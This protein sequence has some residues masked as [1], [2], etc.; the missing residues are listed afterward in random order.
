M[1]PVVYAYVVLSIPWFTHVNL[2][3]VGYTCF[4]MQFKMC[5]FRCEAHMA[6]SQ[7]IWATN[8]PWWSL[9]ILLSMLHP[10][11]PLVKQ[12]YL[13]SPRKCDFSDMAPALQK[14][15]GLSPVGFWEDQ[16][17][18]DLPSGFDAR[19]LIMGILVCVHPHSMWSEIFLGG[20][21]EAWLTSL[22]FFWGVLWLVVFILFT[23]QGFTGYMNNCKNLIHK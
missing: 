11:V 21:V 17:I 6:G 3:L 22:G 19:M 9:S 5:I 20:W 15:R 23:I 13:L 2:C 12:C 1:K 4:W 16:E 10:Q 14:Y 7:V 18:L 8:Y